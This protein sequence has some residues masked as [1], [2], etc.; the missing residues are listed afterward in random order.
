VGEGK[1]HAPRS[2]PRGVR[3][4]RVA[5]E[6]ALRRHDHRADEAHRRLLRLDAQPLH[7]RPRPFPRRPRDV[8]PALR[9]RPHLPRRLHGELVPALPHGPERSGGRARGGARQ[10]LAHPLSG[11]GHARALRHRRDDAAGD[12][13]RR[14]RRLREPGRR[15][16][17][18]PARQDGHPASHAARNSGHHRPA[19]RPAVRHRRGESDA[20]ARPERLRG[21][22]APQPAARRCHRARRAHDRSRWPLRRTRPLRGAAARARRPGGTGAA[23]KDR[24]LYAERRQVPALQD[25][26]GAARVHAMVLPHEAAGRARHPRR[27]GRPHPHHSGKLR[28]DVFRVDAQHPRLVHLAPAL[29][30]PPHPRLALRR[31]PRH[32]CG[33]RGPGA[34]RALRLGADP[35][36]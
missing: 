22:P 5:V 23:G 8:R 19:G 31:L 21:R 32:D 2:R 16:L 25:G 17:P 30:G 15:A 6:G 24:A 9:E 26:G 18:R 11:E 4:P 35:P 12:D 27:R 20:G 13:A 34:L 33:A 14:H 36:G 7:A 29:V 1:A 3:P 28:E 10:P